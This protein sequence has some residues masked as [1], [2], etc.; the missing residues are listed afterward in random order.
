[1]KRPGLSCDG[2][3][4]TAPD[5]Q[6]HV[7]LAVLDGLTQQAAWAVWGSDPAAQA[8][9]CPGRQWRRRPVAVGLTVC[10]PAAKQRSGSGA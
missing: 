6:V 3:F 9:G 5:E 10:R 8:L 1:V 4:T 7:I 2:L